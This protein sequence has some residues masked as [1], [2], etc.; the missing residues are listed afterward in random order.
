MEQVPVHLRPYIVTN[1]EW[2]DLVKKQRECDDAVFGSWDDKLHRRFPGIIEQVKL[3]STLLKVG[4]GLQ[5]ML[6]LHAFGVPTQEILPLV[7]KL[8]GTSLGS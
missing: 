6:L 3:Q 2:K 8:L 5:I 4:I 7:A 1:Q